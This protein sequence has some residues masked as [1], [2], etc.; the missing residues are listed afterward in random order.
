MLKWWRVAQ[1][2]ARC[3][4]WVEREEPSDGQGQTEIVHGLWAYG[5]TR[6][7]DRMAVTESMLHDECEEEEAFEAARA[8]AEAKA[9]GERSKEEGA[10]L[11]GWRTYLEWCRDEAGEEFR[12]QLM[13]VRGDYRDPCGVVAALLGLAEMEGYADSLD[14]GLVELGRP[15]SVAGNKD[16]RTSR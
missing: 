3:A 10:A 11:S 16:I 12:R 4:W 1:D 15:V 14:A 7:G 6:E 9:G 2:S 5:V 8:S 13:D